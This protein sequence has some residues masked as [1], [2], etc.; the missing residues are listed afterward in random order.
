VEGARCEISDGL[1]PGEMLVV[2][3]MGFLTDGMPVE[4][5]RLEDIK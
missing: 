5:V 4:V 1:K 2:N 3:G